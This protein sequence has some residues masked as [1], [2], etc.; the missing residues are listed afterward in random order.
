MTPTASNSIVQISN[1]MQFFYEVLLALEAA[2]LGWYQRRMVRA[3]IRKG[4]NII[5]QYQKCANER[6]PNISKYLTEAQKDYKELLSKENININLIQIGKWF[7]AI[8]SI[9]IILCLLIQQFNC[10]TPIIH[11]PCNL[12]ECGVVGSILA[13][14]VIIQLFYLHFF[15]YKFSEKITKKVE[16]RLDH[17]NAGSTI[18]SGKFS[19]QNT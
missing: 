2:I 8:I 1:N 19:Q 10:A 17:L 3:A 15:I 6:T 5:S 7:I 9:V 16:E 13:A 18:P 4:K 12:L 14:I 11:T